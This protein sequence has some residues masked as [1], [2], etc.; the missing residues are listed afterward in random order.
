M[1]LTRYL[2]LGLML[3]A[4]FACDRGREATATQVAVARPAAQ[5]ATGSV[6]VSWVRP[7]QNTDGSPL[8]DVAGYKLYYGT[9]RNYLQR[10]I[11]IKDPSATSYTMKN[12]P[13]YT[14]YFAITAYNSRGVESKRSNIASKTVP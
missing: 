7:T 4:L 11:D 8:A 13:P 2:P 3:L 6:T 14:Y 5:A 12:L 1:L 10:V 9:S